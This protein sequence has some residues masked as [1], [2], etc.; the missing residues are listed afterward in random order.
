M[1]TDSPVIGYVPLFR[2][3][4]VYESNDVFGCIVLAMICGI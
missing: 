4:V 2:M 3:R 1:R